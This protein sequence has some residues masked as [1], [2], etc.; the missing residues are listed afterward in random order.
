MP[1]EFG[2]IEQDEFG[3]VP[4]KPRQPQE[5]SFWQQSAKEARPYLQT[6]GA[7]AGSIIGFGS[8]LLTGPGAPAASPIGAVVGGGIGFG[9][10][11]E[12]ADM[13]E[14][15]AGTRTPQPLIVELKEAPARVAEGMAYEASGQSLGPALGVAGKTVMKVPA[16]QYAVTTFKDL[17]GK[18]PKVTKEGLQK[19]A[20]KFLYAN[21]S[22]GPIIAKNIE[23]AQAIEE[24]I[25]GVKFTYG[26]MTGDPELIKLERA[27]M[28]EP[29]TTAQQ[30]IEQQK[31]TDTAIQ[32]FIKS[33]R[34]EG[35]IGNVI[36]AFGKKQAGVES[37]EQTA[38]QALAT[39]T[40]KLGMGRGTIEAGQTIRSEAAAAERAARKEGGKKFEQVADFEIDA[41]PLLQKIEDI[42]QPMNKLEDIASNVPNREFDRLEQVLS[43]SG[44]KTTPSDLQGFRSE[45]AEN[46]R[47]MKGA[48]QRNRRK[49]ARLN[50]AISAIDDLLDNSATSMQVQ[51]EPKWHSLSTE[52]RL[53]YYNPK[54]LEQGPIKVWDYDEQKYFEFKSKENFD[55]WLEKYPYANI[56]RPAGELKTYYRYG[57]PPESMRSWNAAEGRPE[58]GVSV[59]STPEGSGGAAFFSDRKVYSGKG[60]Q[61]GWGSD[62]EPLIIPEGEWKQFTPTT[63]QPAQSA[64][65]LK[66]ARNFWKEEVIKKFQDSSIGDILKQRGGGYRVEDAQVASKF[67]KP[68]A[69]GQQS[70]K[71]FK[72]AIGGNTKAMSSIE[73]AIKQD[74][75]TKFPGGEITE[76]GLRRWLNQHKLALDELGLTSKFDSVKKAVEQVA[77]AAQFRKSFEKSEAAKLL[78]ADPDIAIK[79]A[80]GE[81][82]V[83]KAATNLMKATAGNKT[84][85]AGLR[86]S[87]ED[88]ILDQSKNL[89]TGMITKIDTLDKLTKKYRPAFNVFYN[90]DKAALEAWDTARQAFRIA[91]KSRKSPMGAGSDTA[92]NLAMQ[93]Y[94]SVGI[95]GGKIGNVVRAFI[96]PLK[97]YE[98]TQIK[99][100][101]NRALLDPDFAYTLMAIADTAQPGII[102]GTIPKAHIAGR[103]KLIKEGILPEYLKRRLTQHMAII[104]G[105]STRAMQKSAETTRDLL[106]NE[107]LVNP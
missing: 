80:L 48:A 90:E 9:I 20:G 21:T 3:G 11:D 31:N 68:G 81:V 57:K 26:E 34:P 37:A 87:L 7:T 53:K 25:P 82:N 6:A 40:E 12:L 15:W 5:L 65:Q 84:A 24:K 71:E 70:A 72:A 79:K 62:G 105:A 43:E 55:K 33:K 28:R 83:G 17:I 69:S 61:V 39:E 22:K 52:E 51:A 45:L 44:N 29:G 101:I 100:L 94:K 41:T 106:L 35:D 73:D 92:E 8:G 95:K 107:G 42:R 27:T 14:N 18:A 19:L 88:F 78:G 59:Y 56:T 4:I 96:N 64:Q 38:Q 77:D 50:Q 85:Q 98:S 76:S 104:T 36:E 60:R 10:G 47:D 66:E 74:L 102:K 97:E 91:Q 46:L 23:T 16:V 1:D 99:K 30:F 75:L 103:E 58:S 67:F 93:F 13:L 86:N 49:E 89:E 32:D 63:I 54:E 2:G